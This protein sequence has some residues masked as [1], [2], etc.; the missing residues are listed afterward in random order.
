MTTK[1][2]PLNILKAQADRIAAFI[3]AADRDKKPGSSFNKKSFR[4]AI[5][6]DD[7]TIILEIAWSAIREQTE[8]ELA[9]YIL[10]L[11]RETRT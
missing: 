6:M 9:K 8:P 5:T 3:K 4:T 1:H 11:M 2:S 10:S 7:K